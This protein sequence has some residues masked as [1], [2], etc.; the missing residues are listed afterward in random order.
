MI[1]VKYGKTSI[2]NKFIRID[3]VKDFKQLSPQEVEELFII[4]TTEF[5]LL[6]DPR[7]K[8]IMVIKFQ[9]DKIVYRY[10]THLV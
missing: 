4:L 8:V 5:K 10:Y 1:N 9:P 3:V 2:G 7:F 6:D